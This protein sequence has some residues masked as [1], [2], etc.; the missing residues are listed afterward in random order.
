LLIAVVIVVALSLSSGL[1]LLL[2]LLLL[3]MMA[4][5]GVVPLTDAAAAAAVKA[6]GVAVGARTG[7]PP[8]SDKTFQNSA[9][10]MLLSL[11]TG[12]SH[13]LQVSRVATV[14]AVAAAVVSCG[15]TVMLCLLACRRPAEQAQYNKECCYYNSVMKEVD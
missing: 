2:L 7:D 6:I 10:V 12:Q 1:E 14:A 4:L 8:S 3:L 9:S 13:E 5:D 11:D 15:V